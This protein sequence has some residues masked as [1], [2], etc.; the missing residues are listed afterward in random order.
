VPRREAP[1]GRAQPRAR[2]RAQRGRSHDGARRHRGA[3]L[4]G[5]HAR[6]QAAHG[7]GRALAEAPV[8]GAGRPGAL[9]RV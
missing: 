7:R 5:Q 3:L 9:F 1:A 4:H 6:G 2:A 8:A